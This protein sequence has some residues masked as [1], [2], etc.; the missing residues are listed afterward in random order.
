MVGACQA[1]GLLL[2]GSCLEAL[3]AME[4]LKEHREIE[5]A[6]LAAMLHMHQHSSLA[7]ADEIHNL[8]NR[9]QIAEQNASERALLLAA[10]LYWHL[11]SSENLRRSRDLVTRYA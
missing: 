2:E 11:G 8:K 1:Y 5:V 4:P 6:V 7:D 10:T 9:L 3:R